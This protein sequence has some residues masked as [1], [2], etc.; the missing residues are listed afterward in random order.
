MIY[1]SYQ[2]TFLA[3]MNAS[4]TLGSTKLYVPGVGES[5]SMSHVIAPYPTVQISLIL[6]SNISSVFLSKPFT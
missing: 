3:S 6:S 1:R 5:V 4:C 2:T